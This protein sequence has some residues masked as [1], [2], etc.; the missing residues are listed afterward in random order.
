MIICVPK[1]TMMNKL[2]LVIAIVALTSCSVQKS[3]NKSADTILF[4]D[5]A[6]ANAHIG[7]CIYDASANKYLYNHQGNKFFVPASNT[8]IF[9]CYA[10]LKYLGDSIPG[11]QYVETA[12][13]IYLFPTGD[14]TFLHKDFAK[15]R[16]ISFLNNKQKPI[17]VS[18]A[19]W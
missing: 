3:I 13:S 11:I 14:P 8:K 4:K 15:Q 5:S 12:D 9:T 17:A 7:I 10:A 16:V 19:N 1:T 6:L 2:I 18:S